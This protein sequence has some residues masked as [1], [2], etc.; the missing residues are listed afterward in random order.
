MLLAK[1]LKEKIKFSFTWECDYETRY[2]KQKY[3]NEG[4]KRRKCGSCWGFD[5]SPYIIYKENDEIITEYRDKN[6]K[7]IADVALINNGEVRYIFEIKV[8]H[9]TRSLV[10]PEP[11][12]ELDGEAFIK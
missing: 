12:F 11:W 6:N 4:D 2:H 7:Y 1:L 9:E 10:R 3:P 8:T 5:Q